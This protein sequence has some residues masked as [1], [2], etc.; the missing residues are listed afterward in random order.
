MTIAAGAL[1]S[2][3][4]ILKSLAST[5]YLATQT[6]LGD[7]ANAGMTAGVTGP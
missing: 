4:D 5:G 7:T 3:A 6:Y 2:A 1:A